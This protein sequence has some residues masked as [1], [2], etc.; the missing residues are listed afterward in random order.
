MQYIPD[1]RLRFA[2]AINDQT[3]SFALHAI[4]T[5]D[6]DGKL[7]LLDTGVTVDTYCVC[8]T[9]SSKSNGTL[10]FAPKRSVVTPY[11]S[12]SSAPPAV[13]P[14]DMAMA[15]SSVRRCGTAPVS[16]QHMTHTHAVHGTRWSVRLRQPEWIR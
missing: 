15:I 9:A 8:A 2:A 3:V 4:T 1:D 16:E 12:V 10:V 5:D 6:W 13:R 11:R 14:S 7:T